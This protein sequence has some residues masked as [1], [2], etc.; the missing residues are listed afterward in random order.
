MV[1]YFLSTLLYNY[2]LYFATLSLL[3]LHN[4]FLCTDLYIAAAILPTTGID[5]PRIAKR[6][7]LHQ[8]KI[9][10]DGSQQR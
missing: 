6:R 1:L 4:C 3:R 10:T 9:N 2:P 8:R 5:A 7:K